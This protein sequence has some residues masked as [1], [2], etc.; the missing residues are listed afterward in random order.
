MMRRTK[1]TVAAGIATLA[2][3]GTGAGVA[4]ADSSPSAPAPAPNSSTPGGAAPAHVGKHHKHGWMG[5]IEH[6]EFT[7]GGAKKHRVLDVQR[8]TV[9]QVSANVVTVRSPDGYTDTYPVTATTKVRKDRK[10]ATIAQVAKGD[11]V[12]VLAA[13]NG[14]TATAK[15]IGDTGPAKH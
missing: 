13:K 1:A 15:R 11:R 6:G 5:R 4:V 12:H 10:P 14:S 2:L 8:G 3:A 9:T 7:V